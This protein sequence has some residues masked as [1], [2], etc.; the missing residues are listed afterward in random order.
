MES[1]QI[2]LHP[3]VLALSRLGGFVFLI[4]IFEIMVGPLVV[5]RNDRE[6][7]CTLCRVSPNGDVLQNYTITI[8]TLTLIL[9]QVI[10]S[11]FQLE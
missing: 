2:D 6:I 11:L 5:L 9:E 3:L 7:P 4:E 10:I 1:A 8:R